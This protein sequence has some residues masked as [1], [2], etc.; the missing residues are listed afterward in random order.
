ML[1]PPL[2]P[3]SGDPLEA[4]WAAQLIQWIK[5]AVIPRSDG[6]TTRVDGNIITA[7]GGSGEA[8]TQNIEPNVPVRINGGNSL[9]GYAVT[10]F[11]NGLDQPATG[12]A[13]LFLVQTNLQADALLPG[14]IVL[15]SRSYMQVI[16]G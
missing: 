14:D 8:V 3:R 16:G 6:V 9:S 5:D 1:T 11:G 2:V 7:L 15:A 12:Q 4:S 10:V 13:T